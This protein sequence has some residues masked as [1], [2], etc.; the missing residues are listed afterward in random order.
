[1]ILHVI[2]LIVIIGLIALVVYFLVDRFPKLG[3]LW[4]ALIIA[5][6]VVVIIGILQ[7]W[8]CGIICTP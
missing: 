5:S 6:A 7:T 3:K 1:M 8:V 4:L 2:H